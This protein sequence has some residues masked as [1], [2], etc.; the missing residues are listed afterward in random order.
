MEYYQGLINSLQRGVISPVYLFYGEEG[1]LKQKAVAKFRETVLTAA[2]DFN[3]DLIEGDQTD[4]GTV[5]ALAENLPFMAEKRLVVVKNAPWFKSGRKHKNDVDGA[6]EEPDSGTAAPLVDYLN[7]PLASTCLILITDDPVDKRKKLFKALTKIGQAVEFAPLKRTET[8]RWVTDRCREAGKTISSG[9]VEVLLNMVGQ[10]GLTGLTAELSK[11]ITFVGTAKEIT[12]P[13]VRQVVT[14]NL[15][16]S[17][18]QVVDAVAS[19]R[20]GP[21]LAGIKGMLALKEPPQRIIAMLARQFR[22]IVQVMELHLQ[23][24]PE[25]E[26]AAKLGLHP[27]VAKKALAQ[28][29]GLTTARASRMLEQ[30]ADL[31][32]AVKTGR[33]EFYPAIEWLIINFCR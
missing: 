21:A 11:L 9:T 23:H 32:V 20:G 6:A 28:S 1:Y 31:D 19:R 25:K 30:L 24:Y 13:D 7:N 22:L 26:I 27:F 10:P 29:R 14:S 5:A 3:F 8:A 12:A 4:A 2:A 18:F 33:Q 17:I 15:E 16:N